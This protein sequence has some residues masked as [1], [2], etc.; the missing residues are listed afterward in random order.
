[1][2]YQKVEGRILKHEKDEEIQSVRRA[3]RTE[4]RQRGPACRSREFLRKRIQTRAEE[5]Y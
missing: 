2:T 1:M 5:K 3:R 4:D